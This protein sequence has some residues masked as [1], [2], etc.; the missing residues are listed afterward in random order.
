MYDLFVEFRVFEGDRMY[1][2]NL[3]KFNSSDSA[4]LFFLY[5]HVVWIGTNQW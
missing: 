4:V 2:I 1:R 3:V 5:T